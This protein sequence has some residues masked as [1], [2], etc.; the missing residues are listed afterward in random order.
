MKSLDRLFEISDSSRPAIVLLLDEIDALVT[1]R[2]QHLYRILDW[3]TQEGAKLTVVA[4]ANTLDLPERVLSNRNHSRMVSY[5]FY[6]RYYN[7]NCYLSILGAT[8]TLL[9]T[10]RS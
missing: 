1:K 10:L 5:P 9:Q 2:Q 8:S 6:F 4:V 3:S 7:C